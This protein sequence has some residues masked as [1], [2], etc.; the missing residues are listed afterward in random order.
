MTIM[1]KATLARIQQTEKEP[2]QTRKRNHK[3]NTLR[4][5]TFLLLYFVF[6]LYIAGLL[7]FRV[8]ADL[9]SAWCFH[10]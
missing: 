7:V 2:T 4:L 9:F 5:D 6:H 1:Q 3:Q 10:V 8:R